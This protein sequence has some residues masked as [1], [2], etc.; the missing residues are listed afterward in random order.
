[1]ALSALRAPTECRESICYIMPTKMVAV[2]NVMCF[3]RHVLECV[4]VHTVLLSFISSCSY[5]SVQSV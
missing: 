2:L 1:V 3:Y 5:V 4:E